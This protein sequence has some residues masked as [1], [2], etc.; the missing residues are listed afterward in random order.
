MSPQGAP[1]ELMDAA[2]TGHRS[3]TRRG[4]AEVLGTVPLFAG[5]STRHLRRVADKATMKR[6][7]PY[8]EIVRSGDR[9]DAFYVILDGTASV[10]RPGKRAIKLHAGDFFGELALLDASPRSATVEAETEVFAMRLGT[11]A[12]K[13]V[14]E[15][16]P[17][18]SLAML[19]TLA[20]RL[21]AADRTV[22]D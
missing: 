19:N 7:A 11:A 17:K 6:Y 1:A 2:L 20:G 10:R 16:E 13:K 3:G 14:L 15:S 4:W 5:L 22:V 9:G 18:V 8:T 21:R 12:F